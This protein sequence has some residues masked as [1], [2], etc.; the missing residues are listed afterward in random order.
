MITEGINLQKYKKQ[1]IFSIKI[2]KRKNSLCY[3]YCLLIDNFVYITSKTASVSP[4]NKLLIK[5]KFENISFISFS[6]AL[7]LY[8]TLL[9]FYQFL[10]VYPLLLY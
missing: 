10:T 1:L 7:G 2:A 3:Y 8:C 6:K 5:L 9:F 4:F